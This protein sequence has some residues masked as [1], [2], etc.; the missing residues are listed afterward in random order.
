MGPN[1]RRSRRFLLPGAASQTRS[2]VHIKTIIA[3]RE[4]LIT[5]VNWLQE[6]CQLPSQSVKAVRGLLTQS[7]HK[8]NWRARAQILKTADWLIRLQITFPDVVPSRVQP[9]QRRRA[10]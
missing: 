6:K 7:W 2:S 1:R 5:E 3:R 4:E 8:S 9:L 10:S